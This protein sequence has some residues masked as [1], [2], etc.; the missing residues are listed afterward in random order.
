MG[1]CRP[2]GH[3]ARVPV[4]VLGYSKAISCRV[5]GQNLLSIFVLKRQEAIFSRVDSILGMD[6]EWFNVFLFSSP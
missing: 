3:P 5:Q 1:L 2:A 4:A 6:P